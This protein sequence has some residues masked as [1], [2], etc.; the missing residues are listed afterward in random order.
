M[1]SRE[2][3]PWILGWNEPRKK[4]KLLSRDLVSWQVIFYMILYNINRTRGKDPFLTAELSIGA[5]SYGTTRRTT[6]A[7]SSAIDLFMWRC[8][9]APLLRWQQEACLSKVPFNV[10]QYIKT[11]FPSLG[12]LAGVEACVRTCYCA[13]TRMLADIT[14]SDKKFHRS[15]INHAAPRI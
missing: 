4:R 1:G 9:L 5:F 7:Q 2:R 13:C 11:A 12:Q 14:A 8:T 15:A 3:I 6:V 10:N